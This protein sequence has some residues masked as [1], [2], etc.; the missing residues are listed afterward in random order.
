[1]FTT[2]TRV[3]M[4][5]TV[6]REDLSVARSSRMPHLFCSQKNILHIVGHT[7]H[8]SICKHLLFIFWNDYASLALIFILMD[9]HGKR[10]Y[11]YTTVNRPTAKSYNCKQ[12]KNI[13][14]LLF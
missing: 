6:N 12:K 8:G 2:T 9:F 11:F 13:N 3:K 10:M 5:K 14:I 1:M 4:S 7:F